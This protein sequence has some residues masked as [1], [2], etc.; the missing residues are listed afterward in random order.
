MNLPFLSFLA[1]CILIGVAVIGGGFEVKELKMPRVGILVRLASM[2]VGVGFIFLALGLFAI[3]K[4]PSL[5][6]AQPGLPASTLTGGPITDTRA[7]TPAAT[8]GTQTQEA[9]TL[10]DTMPATSSDISVFG[11]FSGSNILTWSVQGVTFTGTTYMNGQTGV[12][13]ISFV[14]AD[15]QQYSV[16]EDLQLQQADGRIWYAGSNPRYSGT[17][18]AFPEYR[19]D[20]FTLVQLP[21]GEWTYAQACD[22][23]G[24]NDV[25]VEPAG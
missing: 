1:G 10:T 8:E 4:D 24:C 14:G 19:P 18:T 25:T 15:G 16:D 17:N 12:I 21:D 20:W 2:G 3:E 22:P 5:M 11:G 13:R 23:D 9:A 7:S 6:S